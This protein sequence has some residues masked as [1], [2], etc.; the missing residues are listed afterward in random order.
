MDVLPTV[1]RLIVTIILAAVLFPCCLL[2]ASSTQKVLGQTANA[3]TGA[4]VRGL[5]W[6]GLALAMWLGHLACVRVDR[7]M[8]GIPTLMVAGSAMVPLPLWLLSN[9]PGLCVARAMSHALGAACF[10]GLHLP[11]VQ[12]G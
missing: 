11:F 4:G 3:R 2:I 5:I 6:L 9:R 10:L 7:P 12:A 8:L 1:D